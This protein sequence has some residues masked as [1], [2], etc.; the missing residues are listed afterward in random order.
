VCAYAI[1][2]N[3]YKRNWSFRGS[4]AKM[5]LRSALV[6]FLFFFVAAVGLVAVLRM[7]M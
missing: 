6:A 7:V 1:S 3:E 5:A 2:Y 4:A